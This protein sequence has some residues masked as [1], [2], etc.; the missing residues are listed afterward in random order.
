MAPDCGERHTLSS[1]VVSAFAQE[2]LD[3]AS[4]LQIA[5]EGNCAKGLQVKNTPKRERVPPVFL[6]TWLALICMI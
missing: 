5:V 1:F 6:V 2:K 4:G 3:C